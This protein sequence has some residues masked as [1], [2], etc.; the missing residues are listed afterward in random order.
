MAASGNPFDGPKACP[1]VALE[2]DRDRRSERPDYRHRCF[3][4]ATPAP[5]SIAHQEAYCLS[6]GF[7]A[8]PIFQDWA[9]RAAARPV[10]APVPEPA[11][12]AATVAASERVDAEPPIEDELPPIDDPL[13]PVTPMTSAQEDVDEPIAAETGGNDEFELDAPPPTAAAPLAPTPVPEPWDDA[14]AEQD[15]H[16]AAAVAAGAARAW[17]EPDRTEQLS[18]FDDT[19]APNLPGALTAPEL[20]PQSSWGQPD[21]GYQEPPDLETP[22][23]YVPPPAR[24]DEPMPIEEEAAVPAFLAGRAAQRPSTALPPPQPTERVKREELVPSWEI[25]GR[26][27]AESPDDDRG[28]GGRFDSLLTAI[29]VIA[30]LALGVAGVLFLP[31]LLA[32]GP[33]PSRT[34][35]PSAALPSGLPSALPSAAASLEPTTAPA[36]TEA[37]AVAPTTEPSPAAS[38]R[39]YRVRAGDTLFRIARRFD[40]TVDAILA[41]NPDISDPNDIFVGQFIAIPQP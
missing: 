26:Y 18:V 28:G 12:A 11:I 6:P 33:G 23:G 9:L 14:P 29:A 40:T 13:P 38:P 25:D 36:T 20:D 39:L 4:E 27:G 3:A 31:G 7:S 19:P 15:D 5:R 21:A 17:D 24:R 16:Q 41:A 2:L 34:A 10:G 22:P 1:F 8:C 30:I 35:A 37:T 32:G